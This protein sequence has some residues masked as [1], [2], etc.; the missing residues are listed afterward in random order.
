M[1]PIA[2]DRV[3]W[4]VSVCGSVCLLVTF[5]NPAKMAAP[6][7]AMLIGGQTRVDPKNH[8]LDGSPESLRGKGNWGEL[9]LAHLKVL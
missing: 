4:S 1:R 3:A 9:S 8:V 7:I 6:S 5:G 2:T